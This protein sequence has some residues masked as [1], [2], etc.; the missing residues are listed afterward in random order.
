MLKILNKSI[1][2]I[3]KHSI[4]RLSS[5]S[6]L[7]VVDLRSDTLTQPSDGLRKA[8]AAAEVGANLGILLPDLG[9]FIWNKVRKKCLNLVTRGR[10]RHL[11]RGF[12]C[13]T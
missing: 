1:L 6:S 12:E 3:Q 4:V 8:M 2:S 7:N 10:R 5:A 13:H 9:E 11:R